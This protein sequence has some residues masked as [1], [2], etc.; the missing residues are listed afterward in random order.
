MIIYEKEL[1]TKTRNALPTSDFALPKERKY[2]IDTVERARNALARV[3]AN[4]TDAEKKAVKA[5]VHKKYPE[6][7]ISE[8][9]GWL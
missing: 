7:E 4:G 8:D 6:V 3:A 5:A 2:P 9:T 1:D